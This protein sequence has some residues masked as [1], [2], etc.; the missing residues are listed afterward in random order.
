MPLLFTEP[1]AYLPIDFVRLACLP[2]RDRDKL[3]QLRLASMQKRTHSRGSYNALARTTDSACTRSGFGTRMRH[4]VWTRV[5]DDPSH[6]PARAQARTLVN[7][8]A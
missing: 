4:A 2:V 7:S 8:T 6:S 3:K 1:A 5:L